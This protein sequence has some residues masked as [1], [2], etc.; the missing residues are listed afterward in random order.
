ML[1]TLK[2]KAREKSALAHIFE[3]NHKMLWLCLVPENV[4]EMK[5]KIQRKIVFFSLDD[6]ENMMEKINI[7]E[8]IKKKYNNIFLKK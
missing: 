8:N 3:N 4:K 2:N 7:K 1:L 6:M 5:K